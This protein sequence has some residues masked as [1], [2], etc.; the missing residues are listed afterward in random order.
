MNCC[1]H[2]EREEKIPDSFLSNRGK[3]PVSAISK[4]LIFQ[5]DN[6]QACAWHADCSGVYDARAVKYLKLK[7]FS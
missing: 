2:L 7:C 5:R 6:F 3:K 1:E 4:L